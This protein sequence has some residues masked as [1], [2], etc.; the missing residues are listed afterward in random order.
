MEEKWLGD[1][2]MEEY[3]TLVIKEISVDTVRQYA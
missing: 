3:A 2:Y 1:K